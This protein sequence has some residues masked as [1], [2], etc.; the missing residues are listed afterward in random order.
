MINQGQILI[1]NKYETSSELQENEV[2]SVQQRC[3][4]LRKCDQALIQSR[5]F[6][7]KRLVQNCR[8][9]IS[10]PKSGVSLYHSFDPILGFRLNL[11]RDHSFSRFPKFS[12]KLDWKLKLDQNTSKYKHTKTRWG[13]SGWFAKHPAFMCNKFW[14][15]FITLN[16]NQNYLDVSLN[17]LIANPTKWSNT[18]KQFVSVF[19]YFV[20]LKGYFTIILTHVLYLLL[21]VF[22]NTQSYKNT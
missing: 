22:T 3:W 7:S 9:I 6:L 11:L 2:V 15:S 10:I 4:L 8:Y 20:R 5:I 1:S 21:F 13:A 16:G 18:P 12:E 19:D 14:T 17:P